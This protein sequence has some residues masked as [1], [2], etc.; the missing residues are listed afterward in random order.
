MDGDEHTL[1]P[2]P[3][4]NFRRWACEGCVP[5]LIAPEAVIENGGNI[6]NETGGANLESKLLLDDPT[7]AHHEAIKF[8]D[9]SQQ[10]SEENYPEEI[11]VQQD[12]SV[13]VGN[14]EKQPSLHCSEKHGESQAPD[15]IRGGQHQ[16]LITENLVPCS[17]L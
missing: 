11:E 1:S 4:K 14:C 10:Q 16:F 17:K 9:T 15:L 12:S 7:K 2:L 13:R 3:V 6:S 5:K 8:L